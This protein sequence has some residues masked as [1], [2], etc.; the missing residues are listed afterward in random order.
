MTR[1]QSAQLD[2]ECAFT[3]LDKPSVAGEVEAKGPALLVVTRR[4]LAGT[5]G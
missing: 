1:A 4:L 3:A 2:S 5:L